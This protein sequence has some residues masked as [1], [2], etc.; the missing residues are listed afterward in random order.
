MNEL[1][2]ELSPD[3]VAACQANAE[4]VA[5]AFS[6]GIDAEVTLA[7]GDAGTLEAG[8]PP[9]DF[10]GPGLAILL[11]FGDVGAVALLP[12]ATGL[13]P[14]WVAKPDPT[15]ISKLSTLA[16]ELSMLLV[17]ETL[18]ADQFAAGWVD[19]LSAALA[20]AE[21]ADS[22]AL[23]PLEL[24]GGE[25]SGQ[26]SLVW[27]CA[28]PGKLLPAEEVEEAIV[29][30]EIAEEN[31]ATEK[32]AAAAAGAAA[33]QHSSGLLSY[34]KHLLRIKVPVSVTLA[35]K[36]LAVDELIELGPGAMISF[37]KSCDHPLDLCVGNQVVATGSAVK[38]GDKFGLEILEMTLPEEQFAA[39]RAGRAS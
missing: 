39:V 20:A 14:D 4:D 9:D 19:S 25:K 7:V 32:P 8:T 13:L 24:T 28:A 34:A 6:R 11:Q 29:A 10:D 18:M 3:V 33:A 22:A 17:P 1:S 12:A 27:P 2:P 35:V 5:G 15:G 36:K 21:P 30:E 37:D 26:L 23:V 16:Q 38:V 31:V